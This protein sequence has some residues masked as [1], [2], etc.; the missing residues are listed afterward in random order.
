MRS[1]W[2]RH[3]CKILKPIHR[4]VNPSSRISVANETWGLPLGDF[5]RPRGGVSKIPTIF[6]AEFTH[7]SPSPTTLMRSSV[8][9][10]STLPGPRPGFMITTAEANSQTLGTTFALPP[11]DLGSGFALPSW[12][13]RQRRRI[14]IPRFHRLATV[15][16]HGRESARA[17][18]YHLRVL[19]EDIG[20]RAVDGMGRGEILDLRWTDDVKRSN[21][22][23]VEDW[24]NPSSQ[25]IL[26]LYASHP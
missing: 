5:R 6:H 18:P 2:G 8:S 9:T 10:S 19:C 15:S 23:G 26:Q 4:A 13:G 20:V 24:T 17:L 11:L 22:V 14:T 3:A 16:S 1:H 25:S 21:T 7:H 12:L